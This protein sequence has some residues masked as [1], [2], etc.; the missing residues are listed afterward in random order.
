[1]ATNHGNDER[2]ER[3]SYRSVLK[4]ALDALKPLFTSDES[5]TF[6][7]PL[8]RQLVALNIVAHYSFNYAQQVHYSVVSVNS[9]ISV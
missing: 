8:T 4:T 2:F 9:L 3:I 7:P 1:M 5:D 6:L